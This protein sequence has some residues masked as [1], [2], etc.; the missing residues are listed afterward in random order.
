MNLEGLTKYAGTGKLLHAINIQHLAMSQGLPCRPEVLQMN[1]ARRQEEA[2][3]FN[4]CFFP[5][6]C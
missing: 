1:P 3:E 2:Q 4:W 5:C 6:F